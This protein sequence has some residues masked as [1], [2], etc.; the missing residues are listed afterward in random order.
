[1]VELL[2]L[3]HVFKLHVF[4]KPPK[5]IPLSFVVLCEA[6]IVKS[7]G[8]TAVWMI[9]FVLVSKLE[10]VPLPLL[11]AD[12]HYSFRSSLLAQEGGVLEQDRRRPVQEWT[13]Q[14]VGFHLLLLRS[15][16]L[17]EARIQLLLALW[18]QVILD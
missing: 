17:C 16:L 9:G 7:I 10:I 6:G 18:T 2:V 8:D 12:F 11:V 1:M 13:F 14:E 4:I 15:G 3:V 5:S